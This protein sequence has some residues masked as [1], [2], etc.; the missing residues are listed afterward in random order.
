[1]KTKIKIAIPRCLSVLVLLFVI[2]TLAKAQSGDLQYFR[3][4][5]QRGVNVFEAPKQD[6]TKFEKVVVKVGGD[7]AQQYQ[8]LYHINNATPVIVGGVNQTA[9]NDLGSGFNTATAN[10]NLETVRKS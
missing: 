6:T 3:P 10:L 4:Y 8:S 1:M 2:P 5:D 7:F 9:L